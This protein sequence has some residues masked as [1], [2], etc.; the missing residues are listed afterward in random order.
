MLVGPIKPSP[1]KSLP[2]L[3]T[4]QSSLATRGTVGRKRPGSA[5]W[6]IGRPENPVD[7]TVKADGTEFWRGM[8]TG[9]TVLHLET[10][11]GG[12]LELVVGLGSP[13]RAIPL[14]VELRHGWSLTDCSARRRDVCPLPAASEL[15]SPGSR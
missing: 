5:S 8:I 2:L 6:V 7:L 4:A 13:P 11:V 14:N 9:R 12:L 10:T 15:I 1:D 3:H